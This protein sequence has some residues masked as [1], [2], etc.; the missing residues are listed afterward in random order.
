MNILL[1]LNTLARVLV[2]FAMPSLLCALWAFGNDKYQQAS[3]FIIVVVVALVSAAMLFVAAPRQSGK[4]GSKETVWFLIITWLS[5]SSLSSIPFL[6]VTEGR[7]I[8]ALF[9]AVSCTTTTGASLVS[10]DT[11]LSASLLAWR[12]WLHIFGAVLSISGMMMLLAQSGRSDTGVFLLRARTIG[13]S[14]RLSSFARLFLTVGG[15]LV[16][17]LVFCFA[18]L[19]TDGLS[20]RE[21]FALSAGAI[22]TG[23]IVP[24]DVGEQV[25]SRW[26]GIFLSLVLLLACVNSGL[27]LSIPRNFSRSV[28]DHETVGI[29][30]AFLCLAA[31]LSFSQP[32]VNVPTIIS[33]AASVVS[34]SGMMISGNKIET[35]GIPILIFFGFTGGSAISATGGMKM[36]RMRLLMS[37]AVHEFERLSHP[38][39]VMKWH[40]DREGHSVSTIMAVWVYLV[41]FAVV[42][43]GLAGFLSVIGLDFGEALLV[44]VGAVTNSAALFRPELLGDYHH[45]LTQLILIFSMIFGRLEL[46]ILISLVF[47][48]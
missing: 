2:I 8:L 3:L 32:D 15:L 27:L 7:L 31:L 16:G 14:F 1:I 6:I 30:V 37:R 36:F 21:A 12:G 20:V 48:A 22:T 4:A 47:R 19:V 40:A 28:W 29:C 24:Y 26:T 41:G 18:V 17:M 25:A 5:I 33:E 9:E 35:V 46:L 38:Q 23:Q 11:A 34:S 43:A 39:A 42:A 13:I 45:A 44:S 10:P